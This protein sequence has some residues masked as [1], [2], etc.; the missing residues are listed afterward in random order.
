MGGAA[1]T[2]TLIHN[3]SAESEKATFARSRARYR[4]PSYC[5][6]TGL[7]SEIKG[8][9]G[10]DWDC[11]KGKS[12]A[13]VVGSRWTGLGRGPRRELLDSPVV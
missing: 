4:A 2:C 6:R 11:G 5:H 8:D 7:E 9:E 10:L 1:H 12:A 3:A 13:G